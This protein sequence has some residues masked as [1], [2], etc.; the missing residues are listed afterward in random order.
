MGM[1]CGRRVECGCTQVVDGAELVI[2]PAEMLWR[3]IE[4]ACAMNSRV[5]VNL[6]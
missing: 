2:T 1:G 6:D 5:D 3:T 4:T